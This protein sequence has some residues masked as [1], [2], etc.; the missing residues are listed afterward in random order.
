MENTDD[1][2]QLAVFP[3]RMESL[4]RWARKE[5]ILTIDIAN[6]GLKSRMTGEIAPESTVGTH[7]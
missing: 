1:N 4:R 6:K 3:Q 7:D 5:S 2:A